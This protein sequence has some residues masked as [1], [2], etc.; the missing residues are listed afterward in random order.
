M[1]ATAESWNDRFGP[2]FLQNVFFMDMIE[3]QKKFGR[4]F[5]G[6][7]PPKQ[8]FFPAGGVMSEL[9]SKCQD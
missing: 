4:V 6:F 7:T 5:L 8:T 3:A 9:R 2:F 1:L